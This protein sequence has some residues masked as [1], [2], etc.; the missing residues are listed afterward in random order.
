MTSRKSKGP[1]ERVVDAISDFMGKPLS[2]ESFEV[3]TAK[4]V[5]KAEADARGSTRR[6]AKRSSAKKKR[7][8]AKKRA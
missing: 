1:F 4:K 6:K 8:P 2:D 5:K 7:A 3:P